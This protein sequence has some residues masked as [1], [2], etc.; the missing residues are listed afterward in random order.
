MFWLKVRLSFTATLSK[1]LMGSGYYRV[2]TANDRGG[3][4]ARPGK[5][6][7]NLDGLEVASGFGRD[8]PCKQFGGDGDAVSVDLQI[9]AAVAMADEPYSRIRGELP[10]DHPADAV[11]RREVAHAAVVGVEHRLNIAGVDRAG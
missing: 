6:E 8:E 11:G 5:V 2:A 10:R 9:G 7:N 3:G 4:R 1:G